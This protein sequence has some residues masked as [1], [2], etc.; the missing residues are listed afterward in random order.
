M[1]LDFSRARGKV[2]WTSVRAYIRRSKAMLTG[3]LIANM[4]APSTPKA[5]QLLTRCPNLEYLELRDIVVGLD[6]YDLFKNSKRLRTFITSADAHV[7]EE[8]TVK[9]LTTLPLIERIEIHNIKASR[10]FS[11]EWPRELPNLKRITLGT[12]G[13]RSDYLG[14]IIIPLVPDVCVLIP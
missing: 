6:F 9:L 11:F 2:Y 4:A 13:D 10:P 3:A 12:Q 1:H 14:Q 5:L 8:C 7:S